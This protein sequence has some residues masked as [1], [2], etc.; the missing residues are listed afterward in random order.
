MSDERT[1][2]SLVS[3]KYIFSRCS[4]YLTGHIEKTAGLALSEGGKI[5]LPVPDLLSNCWFI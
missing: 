4:T 2:T 5:H 3:A 1:D